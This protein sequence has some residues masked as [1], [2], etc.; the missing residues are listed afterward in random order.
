MPSFERP[1]EYGLEVFTAVYFAESVS[2]SLAVLQSY[3]F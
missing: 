2:Q 1:S 3:S